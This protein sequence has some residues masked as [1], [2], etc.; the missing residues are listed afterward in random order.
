M[1]H[2][3]KIDLASLH[4]PVRDD[5]G[6]GPAGTVTDKRDVTLDVFGDSVVESEAY[7]NA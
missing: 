4:T 5:W 2:T 3:P 6:T 1:T 7:D